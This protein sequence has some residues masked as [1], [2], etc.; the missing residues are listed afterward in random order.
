[1]ARRAF[2]LLAASVG[3]LLLSPLLLAIGAAVRLDSRGPALFR[4]LRVGR[5]E[6]PFVIFK[7]RT[8]VV[9]G[10]ARGGLLTVA[11][12]PR[13][14]RV[15]RWLRRSKLD[16]LPQLLNVIR[17]DM[18]LVG[19]RPEVPRYVACYDERQRRVLSVRP[20]ITDPASIRFRNENRLL[21]G[22]ADPEATYLREVLPAK[23][24]MNLAYLD[25]RSLAS[26][27]GILLRTVAR[28]LGG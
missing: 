10:V 11:D 12:D 18:A 22:A 25:R 8:M 19:P 6:R 16:E 7:F 21:A 13:V 4:Q 3:L 27:V 28:L 15:G 24:E 1:M 9:D 17:G 5:G 23:L 20:G 2:D 26:D 14:T